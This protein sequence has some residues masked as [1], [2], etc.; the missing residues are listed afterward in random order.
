MTFRKTELAGVFVIE[1]DRFGDHRGC[2]A[3]TYS[4]RTFAKFGINSTFVQDNH[5]LSASPGMVRG[6]HFQA[7]PHAQAE[8]V[9]CCRG[10][11][12]TLRSIS[13]REVQPSDSGQAM[14]LA[15]KM[16][17][18]CLSQPVLPMAS[19]RRSPIARSSTN[20]A[21]ITRLRPRALSAG[22][23]RPLA[24]YGPYR[25][26]QSSAARMLWH[27]FWRIWTAHLFEGLN[28]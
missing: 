19:P 13:G 11:I 8:L 1:L 9:L 23:T 4:H 25:A 12:L 3:E 24:P 27:R 28:T 18:S 17:R 10:A 5:S 16:A 26:I 15:P 20:A 22:M 14:S 7:P 2:L 21:I 6:L